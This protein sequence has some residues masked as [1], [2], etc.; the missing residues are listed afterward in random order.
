MGIRK[1]PYGG[2]VKVGVGRGAIV[3]VSLCRRDCVRKE[4]LGQLI[5]FVQHLPSWGAIVWVPGQQ[6]RQQFLPGADEWVVGR[7]GGIAVEPVRSQASRA[8]KL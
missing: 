3:P 2:Y 1:R 4:A 8:P 6:R 7:V 5:Q